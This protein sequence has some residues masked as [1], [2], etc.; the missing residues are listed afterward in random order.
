M[1]TVGHLL[2]QLLSGGGGADGGALLELLSGG[3]DAG[4]LLTLLGGS[5]DGAALL[6]SVLSGLG[7][8][9]GAGMESLME[10]IVQQQVESMLS[11]LNVGLGLIIRRC[12]L[13]LLCRLKV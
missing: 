11:E 6:E 13:I 10:S 7:G 1:G 8:A 4:S 2:E 3:G 12:L 9:D 5:G